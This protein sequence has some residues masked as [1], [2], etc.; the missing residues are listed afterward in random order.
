MKTY[1]IKAPG[2]YSN[3]PKGLLIAPYGCYFDATLIPGEFEVGK[4]PYEQHK[5]FGFSRGYH[6]KNSFRVGFIY[7]GK[8]FILTAYVYDNGKKP[9]PKYSVVGWINLT[10]TEA[11]LNIESFMFLKNQTLTICGTLQTPEK[12]YT[13]GYHQPYSNKTLFPIGYKL[14]FAWGD[15]QPTTKDKTITIHKIEFL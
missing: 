14:G 3:S 11:Y 5:L 9:Y 13:F 8:K 1:T 4:D 12:E 10:G 15:N 6:H 7:T 2:H